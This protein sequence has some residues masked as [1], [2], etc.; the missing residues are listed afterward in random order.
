MSDERTP[1][2][3]DLPGTE[4]KKNKAVEEVMELLADAKKKKTS[5]NNKHK[6]RELAVIE[7]MKKQELTEYT[8]LD[9]GIT[10]T[11]DEK[12]NAKLSA[13]KPDKDEKAEKKSK[14]AEA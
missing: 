13:Y 5:A 3:T 7:V 14:T 4:R 6:E 10:V 12:A 11:I 8:S 9:L 2:Q 1:R